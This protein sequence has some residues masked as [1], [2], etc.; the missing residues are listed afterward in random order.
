MATQERAEFTALLETLTPEQ[1]A[2]PSLCAGWTVHDVVAHAISYEEL[3]P[4]EVISRLGR[5]MFVP[6][7]ANAFGLADY[8]ERSSEELIALYQKFTRPQGLTTSFGG[9]IALCDGMIHQ[10]DV[11]RPLG[12]PREIPGE[13]IAPVLTFAM[14]APVIRG[15]LHTRGV[16]LVAIDVDWSFGVGPEASGP[17]EALLMVMSGRRGIV[18]ELSG[19]GTEKLAARLD[20]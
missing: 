11:R 14:W 13:R 12:L 18:P 10:Q 15:A 2:T 8:R 3:G 1:W 6:K 17:A 9:R 7:R 20:R 4:R 5:G 19:P 16:R